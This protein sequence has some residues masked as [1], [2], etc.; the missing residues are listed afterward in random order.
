MFL[1][2]YSSRIIIREM[3]NQKDTETLAYV[4]MPD[5]VHW[6]FQ[7]N[8]G[9]SLERIIRRVKGVSA[10]KINLRLNREGSIW[11]HGFFDHAVRN[12]KDVKPIARYII[13]NPLRAGL[14]SR[15]ADYPHWDAVWV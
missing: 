1:N 3:L 9:G 8:E 6:L 11:Q 12:Q 14:V 13:A 10:R 7:L 4:V 2:L 15:L 5:H